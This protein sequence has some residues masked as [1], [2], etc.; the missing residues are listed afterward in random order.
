M[1]D[2]GTRGSQTARELS[3]TGNFS[4]P[5]GTASGTVATS[6]GVRLTSAVA[7]FDRAEHE[8][9]WI[10]AAGQVRR[11]RH[12][13]DDQ[14]IDTWTAFNPALA[15]VA[16]DIITNDRLPHQL[17]IAPVGGAV[18]LNT[19]TMSVTIPDGQTRSYSAIG[20]LEPIA[21][22]SAATTYISVTE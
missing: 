22:N 17:G 1:A 10:Y 9:M 20:G 5:A 13:Y 3:V 7:F 14:T 19:D 11:I 15:A 21:G 4:Y 12:V 18:T 6:T 16:F 2:F 8:R